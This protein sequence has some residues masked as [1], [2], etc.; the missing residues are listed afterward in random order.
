MPRYA[1]DH[2]ERQAIM[3][4]IQRL[5]ARESKALEAAMFDCGSQRLPRCYLREQLRSWFRERWSYLVAEH[6]RVVND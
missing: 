6:E 1:Y 5:N 4:C 3:K 2:A